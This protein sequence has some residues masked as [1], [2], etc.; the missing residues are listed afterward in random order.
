MPI[1]DGRLRVP[2]VDWLRLAGSGLYAGCRPLTVRVRMEGTEPHPKWYAYV[3]Y[4][5]PTAQA[6]QPAAD[7]ALGLHRKRA[8]KRDNT[9][10]QVSR[11]P[12]ETAHTVAIEDLNTQGM[13]RSAK[14]T[15]AKPGKQVKQKA[16]LNRSIL[17]SGWGVL[18]RQ[19]AYTRRGPC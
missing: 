8:H 2:K 13:I 7:G 6:R 15:V 12:A 16:G 3:C 10:H 14:G 9:T 18:E 1:R 11:K 4:A 17:A 5:V 19:L